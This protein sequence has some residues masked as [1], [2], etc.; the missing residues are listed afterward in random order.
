[1]QDAQTTGTGAHSCYVCM[2]GV[3]LFLHAHADAV[4]AVGYRAT[5]GTVRWGTREC[6]S[7][8]MPMTASNPLPAKFP[9]SGLNVTLAS[10]HTLAACTCG[11]LTSHAPICST[12]VW[13]HAPR[14][15][16]HGDGRCFEVWG[17]QLNTGGCDAVCGR[18]LL[19]S[20]VD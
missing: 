14:G 1:M 16:G 20:D 19:G 15:A 12:R 18:I 17:P 10:G 8:R 6:T 13:A 11:W 3:I 5:W 9:L 4:A 2:D 7:S